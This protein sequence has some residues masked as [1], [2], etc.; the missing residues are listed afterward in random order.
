[1]KNGQRFE[2]GTHSSLNRDVVGSSPT[3]GVS[4]GLIN[5]WRNELTK[6]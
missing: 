4:L 6:E 1:M 3:C 5:Q 2:V